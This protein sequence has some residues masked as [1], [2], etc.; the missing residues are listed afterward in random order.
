MMVVMAGVHSGDRC[1][2]WVE[3]RLVLGVLGMYAL[4][5]WLMDEI[6]WYSSWRLRGVGL[7]D[8]FGGSLDLFL[9]LDGNIWAHWPLF[10]LDLES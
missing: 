6:W 9:G 2:L 3:S 1:S 10:T 4:Y 5:P 7:L 8:T